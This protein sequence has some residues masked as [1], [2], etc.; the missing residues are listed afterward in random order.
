MSCTHKIISA[1]K[2]VLLAACF[3]FRAINIERLTSPNFSQNAVNLDARRNWAGCI[4]IKTRKH[5]EEFHQLPRVDIS[6]RSSKGKMNVT[7]ASFEECHTVCWV[8]SAVE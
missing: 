1:R 7:G 2:K 8:K 5:N 4:L 6:L 3:I